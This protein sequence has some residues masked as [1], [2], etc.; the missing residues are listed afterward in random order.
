MINLGGFDENSFHDSNGVAYLI[1]FLQQGHG[2]KGII[3]R[4]LTGI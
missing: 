2:I 4:F 3:Q 1:W